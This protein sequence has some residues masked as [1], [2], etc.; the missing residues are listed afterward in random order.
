MVG[1]QSAMVSPPQ[2]WLYMV[3]FTI[4][5]IGKRMLMASFDKKPPAF[6]SV[7][8]EMALNNK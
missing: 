6:T 1:M 7:L 8:L 3:G 5:L 2:K 4:Q